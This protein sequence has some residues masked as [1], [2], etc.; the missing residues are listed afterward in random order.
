[1]IGTGIQSREDTCRKVA[2]GLSTKRLG[3]VD[4]TA[5]LEAIRC[6]SL[7]SLLYGVFFLT[8]KLFCL[9]LDLGVSKFL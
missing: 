4:E 5:S 3:L 8:S 6:Q 9:E 1:M 2:C 7:P